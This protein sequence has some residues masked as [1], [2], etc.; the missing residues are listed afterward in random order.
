M[1]A[2]CKETTRSS[3]ESRGFYQLGEHL[4]PGQVRGRSS[5]WILRIDK[6][7]KRFSGDRRCK[8][9][10]DRCS[11]LLGIP[12]KMEEVVRMNN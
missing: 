5:C 1:F 12:G 7:V 6:C 4:F 2:D 10:V 8:A 11:E 3:A 9:T